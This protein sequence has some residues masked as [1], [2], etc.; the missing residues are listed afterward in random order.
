MSPATAPLGWARPAA[1]NRPPTPPEPEQPPS[2]PAA[3]AATAL[4][5]PS[6]PYSP[7]THG[8]HPSPGQ[9]PRSP[10]PC[11]TEEARPPPPRDRPPARRPHRAHPARL[12]AVWRGHSAA[13]QWA[14]GKAAALH[15][16]RHACV[17][18]GPAGKCSPGGGGTVVGSWQPND[19][20]REGTGSGQLGT[21]TNK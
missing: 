19:L 10:S 17:P 5:K 14:G 18:A 20:H 3:T 16:G 11:G 2:P 9:R 15:D 8:S 4:P 13:H 1:L 6:A 12:R 21:F 7:S